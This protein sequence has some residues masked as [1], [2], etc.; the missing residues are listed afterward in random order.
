[1]AE[2]DQ[3]RAPI[4]EALEEFEK[5]RV[6]PFDVP[7]HKRGKGN[8]VLTEFLGKRCMSLDVNSM[9]PLD[10]LCHPV[11]VIREAEELAADAFG[12][13]L[14]AWHW[15]TAVGTFFT[16]VVTG[17]DAPPATGLRGVADIV[18]RSSLARDACFGAHAHT[19]P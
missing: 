14:A 16:C 3:N 18:A 13:G 15:R 2:L 5:N 1:M 8:P 11:S 10:N 17:A 12:A 19:Q 4:K 7:G 6:V 9:R